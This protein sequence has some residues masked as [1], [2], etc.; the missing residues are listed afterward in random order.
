MQCGLCLPC[1]FKFGNPFMPGELVCSATIRSHSNIVLQV[2]LINQVDFR[3]GRLRAGVTFEVRCL[4]VDAPDW[5]HELSHSWPSAISLFVDDRRV[6]V[7]K[8]DAEHDEA[9]GPFDLSS[10]IVRAPMEVNPRPLK[11]SAAVTAKKSEQ[12][13]IGVLLISPVEDVEVMCEEVTRRQVPEAKRMQEDLLRVRS[14]VTEHRPD[15]VDRKDTLR[16]VEPPVLKLVCCTSLCRIERAA[17][18][19]ECD[20]LQCFDLGSYLQTMKNIPPKHAWCCPI[21]DKPVPLHRIRLDAFAQSVIDGSE[22]NVTEVLVADSGKWEVSATEEP[23]SDDSDMSDVGD[24]AVKFPP[25]KPVKPMSQADLQAAALNLGRSFATPAP[26]APEKK[27]PAPEKKASAPEA[28][29]PSPPSRQRSRSPRRKNAVAEPLRAEVPADRM[30]A[31]QKLQGLVKPEPEPVKEETRIGWLPDKTACSMCKK[32]VVEKGGVYCGRKRPDG[33]YGGC[34]ASICWKCMNKGGKELGGVRTTKA[35]FA[36]LGPGA[37]W[38]HESCM[39][40]EDKKAYFGEDEDD[41][42]KKCDDSDDEP[43]KFAWE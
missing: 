39:N 37:W 41:D 1:R 13:A 2:P 6:L 18:G 17:R 12:W 16:C 34:F 8:P 33:T 3:S 36:S 29:A 22:A 30:L 11:V 15:R 42:A 26:K 4:R 35:E 38:M 7:R 27:A 19:E 23:V 9:P 40:A 20:H 31:W 24:V 43:G 14:W 32:A 5:R 25:P 28:P 21:C 10:W